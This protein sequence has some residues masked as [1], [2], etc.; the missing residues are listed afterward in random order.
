VKIGGYT[1][2]TGTPD[3]NQ[4]LS[5]ARADAVRQ[6]LIARGVDGNRIEAKGFG[7]QHPVQP[8]MDVQANR[9]AA[10]EVISP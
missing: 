2:A 8:G 6:E 9:R 3:A 5:Q 4:T 1:D 7:E 10:I